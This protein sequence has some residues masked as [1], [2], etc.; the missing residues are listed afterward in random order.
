MNNTPKQLFAFVL[1]AILSFATFFRLYRLASPSTYVFD[2]V[3]H[4]IT[5]KLMAR[6]DVRA[7]EWWNEPVEPNTAVDWL[8]PPY[9]K[10]TQAFFMYIFGENAFGWRLSAALFGVGTIA[11]TALLTQLLFRQPRITL[12]AAWLASLDGLL[13]VQSR[14]AMND[15]HVT[16]MIL[17]TLC[18]YAQVVRMRT[19]GNPQRAWRWLLATGVL[20]GVSMGTKWS[21]VFVLGIVWSFEVAHLL[22]VRGWRHRALAA[23]ARLFPLALLP[24]LMY[25][26][27]YTQMFLQGKSLVCLGNQVQ[28]GQCYCQQTSSTWVRALQAISPTN[29][30]RA[31]WPTLEARGGCKRLI[32]HFSELHNQILWYQTHLDATHPYESRPLDWVFDLRPVWMHVTYIDDTFIS[33]I[34]N[35]GNAPL[36]WC[37]AVAIGATMVWLLIHIL[38]KRPGVALLEL[39]EVEMR[40]TTR[41]T[42][43]QHRELG[44]QHPAGPLAPLFG[45]CLVCFAYFSMWAPWLFS[46]RIMFFYHYAPAVPLLCI[47]LAWWIDCCLAGPAAHHKHQRVLNAI[48]RGVSVVT[49]LSTLAFFVVWLPQWTNIPVNKKVSD[50]IYYAIPSWK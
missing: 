9:A 10:Y 37:G 17:A 18:A 14:I 31:Y 30:I 3:Y 49:L 8:H 36:F 6:N 24:T 7:F 25:L 33:N 16:F 20:A 45:F 4:A 19:L 50:P 46:P 12:L 1:V 47:A 5:A 35:L 27:S 38:E 26:L 13:L 29:A 2:E 15:I 32:S 41:T 28:Q 39:R 44:D 34:Y 22:F 11:L 48:L 43:K 40:A 42:K 21:G 23:L